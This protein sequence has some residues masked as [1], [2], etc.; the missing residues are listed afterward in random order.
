M[1]AQYT[2][3]QIGNKLT[4]VE[5]DFS[6][7]DDDRIDF[8]EYMRYYQPTLLDEWE[9]RLLNHYHIKTIIKHDVVMQYLY[10]GW[11]EATMNWWLYGDST[12]VGEMI[13][14]YIDDITDRL[15][16]CWE[17]SQIPR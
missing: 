17:Q 1:F 16:D 5:C 10:S 14:I 3:E 6:E 11:N 13:Q 2:D 7:H 9:K 15:Q 12:R 8:I 4:W